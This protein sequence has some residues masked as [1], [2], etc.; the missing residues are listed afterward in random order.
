MSRI[1]IDAAYS[2]RVES[3]GETY[4]TMD[5]DRSDVENVYVDP[6]MDGEVLLALEREKDAITFWIP[7]EEISTLIDELEEYADA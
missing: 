2:Y 3:P 4:A 7:T 5:R 6:P 1:D